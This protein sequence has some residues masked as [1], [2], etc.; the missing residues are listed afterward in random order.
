MSESIISNPNQQGSKGVISA[1]KATRIGQTLQNWQ[2][3]CEEGAGVSRESQEILNNEVG[4]A[5][6]QRQENPSL[7]DLHKQSSSK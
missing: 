2:D 7:N 3:Y 4:S 1:E 5:N 6:V